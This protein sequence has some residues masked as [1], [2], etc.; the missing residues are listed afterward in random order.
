MS[1]NL[2]LQSLLGHLTLPYLSREEFLAAKAEENEQAQ[3]RIEDWEE[4]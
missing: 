4:S 3:G 1:R 2:L